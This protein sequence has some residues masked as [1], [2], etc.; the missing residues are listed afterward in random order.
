MDAQSKLN[1]LR[2]KWTSYSKLDE[3]AILKQCRA[4]LEKYY[5]RFECHLKNRHQV[6]DMI[7]LLETTFDDFGA[8]FADSKGD[9]ILSNQIHNY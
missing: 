3:R 5:K 1:D 4:Q 9:D 2:Q 7:E 6:I 8:D